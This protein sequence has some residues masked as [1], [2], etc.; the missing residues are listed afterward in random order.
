[1][2][3]ETLFTVVGGYTH[4]IVSAVLGFLFAYVLFRLAQK[5]KLYASSEKLRSGP[6]P[7]TAWH[8][9][10]EMSW[11]GDSANT[12]WKHLVE[13]SVSSIS[14]FRLKPTTDSILTVSVS[15]EAITGD[16]ADHNETLSLNT[17]YGFQILLNVGKED[18][19]K[20]DDIEIRFDPAAKII[21][22][23]TDPISAPGYTI[24]THKDPVYLNV[25]HLSVPYLNANTNMVI[26]LITTENANRS[27]IVTVHGIGIRTK[28][29][30]SLSSIKSIGYFIALVLMIVNLFLI[31]I[32]P[33][34][35]VRF[36]PNT[37]QAWTY[38]LLIFAAI[39]T[40][41]YANLL[42][43]IQRKRRKIGQD[44]NWKVPAVSK[45]QNLL[46]RWFS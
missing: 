42:A 6:R 16:P 10:S 26:R 15:K 8:Q 17:V 23:E 45:K 13:Y 21:R 3:P 2:S 4:D 1:M 34:R 36:P 28:L 11:R 44:W 30:K 46:Q 14:L 33:I 25:L 5:R 41:I 7:P 19:E 24:T 38:W 29:A 20:I 27:C 32:L 35:S 40:I 31:Y 12:V 39:V 9:A 18:I 43:R 37:P 22:C